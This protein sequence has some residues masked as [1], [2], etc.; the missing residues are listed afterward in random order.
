LSLKGYIIKRTIY[1]LFILYIVATLNFAIFRLMPGDPVRAAVIGDPRASLYRDE[2]IKLWGLDKPLWD[3][4]WIY[5]STIF[6]GEFGISFVSG[7]PVAKEIMDRLPN[8]LLLMGTSTLLSLVLGIATGIVAAHH[9]GKKGDVAVVTASLTVYS[10][11]IFWI[12]MLFLLVFSF[13][14]GWFPLG[15][16]ITSLDVVRQGY[17][18]FVMDVL[19]HLALPVIA[20]TIYGYGGL[21]LIVRNA[22]IDVLT[23]DYILTARAKGLDD[24]TVLYKHALKNAM[25]PLVTIIALSLAG[26]VGGAI[27]TETIFSW[28][29][30]GKFTF[31]AL[32]NLDYPV[33]QALFFIESAL[34]IAANF[35]ADILYGF[36]D[37]RVRY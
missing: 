26:C 6:R 11:P 20:L 24:R 17:I 21:T 5:I 22:L 15:G 8:T 27:I 14:L 2:L 13:Y 23:E 25:L 35:V 32:M 7:A 10:F 31:D 34:V 4:Y 3:Q 33:L 18:P 30:I 37:P 36:L 29:G 28:Y 9:R 1:N 16:T 19:W 12:G